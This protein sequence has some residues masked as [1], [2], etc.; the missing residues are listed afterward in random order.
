MTELPSNRNFF[1]REIALAARRRATG[2]AVEPPMASALRTLR[3]TGLPVAIALGVTLAVP[4][5]L[6]QVPI[7]IPTLT[8]RHAYEQT[9][10]VQANHSLNNEP[11]RLMRA[12]VGKT[13]GEAGLSSERSTEQA[14]ETGDLNDGFHEAEIAVKQISK[15]PIYWGF[16]KISMKATVLETMATASNHR[17]CGEG[18]GESAWESEG[19]I[20]WLA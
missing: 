15:C 13:C 10:C 14:R 11:W 9:T 7:F 2:G 16:N 6:S 3:S 12:I 8:P 17:P 4:F 1:G 5:A 19:G 18:C 20:K